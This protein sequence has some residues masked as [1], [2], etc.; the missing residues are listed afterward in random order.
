MGGQVGNVVWGEVSLFIC[1]LE[2]QEHKV[3]DAEDMVTVLAMPNIDPIQKS[4][5]RC[6][7]S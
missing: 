5:D 6:F 3:N 1:V 4:L 2:G 7:R